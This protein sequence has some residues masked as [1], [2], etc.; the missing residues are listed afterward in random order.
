MKYAGSNRNFKYD[1][2]KLNLACAERKKMI[3]IHASLDFEKAQYSQV[4]AIKGRETPVTNLLNPK[5]VYKAKTIN[6]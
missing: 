5:F 4:Y 3:I 2:E 6:E 1:D